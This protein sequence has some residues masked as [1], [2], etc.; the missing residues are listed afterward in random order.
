MITLFGAGTLL[1]SNSSVKNT[2]LV[3]FMIDSESSITTKPIFS[4]VFAKR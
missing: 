3:H 1:V 2:L 4:A